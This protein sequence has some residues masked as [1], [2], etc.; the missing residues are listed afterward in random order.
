MWE[1]Y[2]R[3]CTESMLNGNG[4]AGEKKKGKTEAKVVG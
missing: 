4:G 2:P 1:K 3:K